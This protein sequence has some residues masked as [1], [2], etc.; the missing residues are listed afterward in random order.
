MWKAHQIVIKKYSNPSVFLVSFNKDSDLYTGMQQGDNGQSLVLGGLNPDGTDSYNLLSDMCLRASMELKLIDP[1]INL[2]VHKNTDLSI[3]EKGTHLTKQ[4]LGFPQYSNDDIIIPAL[5]A[6]GYDEKDAFNYVVA[7]CWEFI[8]P[9][10]AMDIPNLGALS[11]TEAMLRALYSRNDWNGFEEL[12][13]CVHQQ[14]NIMAQEL[15]DS[16][17]NIYMEPSP[18]MYLLCKGC[19]QSGRDIGRGSKYNNYGIHGTGLSTAVDSLAA[20]K[21]YVFEE[22]SV[23]MEK[24]LAAL[25]N[26]FQGNEELLNKLR[27]SQWKMG[28][29]IDEVDELA[30]KLLDWFADALEGKRNDRGGIFRPGTGS[31]MY[32]IWHSR[33]VQATP[34]GRR[35]GEALA[36][37]YS[38]SLFSRCKGPVSIIKSFTKPNLK[39]V[40]NGG[41]LTI[42]LHDT[43]FR[44]KDSIRKV[45]MFVKS[46]MAMGGHQM[47]L[48]A[49]NRERLIDAKK[50]PNNYRNLIVRVWGWSGYF[51]ELDEVYQD[52]II[53]RTELV[54]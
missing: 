1:K 25:E 42:E 53:E 7:A 54:M 11:F 12:M 33:D 18:L 20:I 43:V 14:I 38:P 15:T 6:W 50:H 13:D 5:C 49:I 10:V 17:K 40:A 16:V 51:V 24:L 2:R 9:D 21:K 35:R 26:D 29:D 8:V 44:N 32:Y 3:Y 27:Y 31:A 52:H 36:C 37:N 45:A 19:V 39:R 4:G 41:P 23:T 47:Q 22:Q 30:C 48:N 28:N 34:D 46:Y